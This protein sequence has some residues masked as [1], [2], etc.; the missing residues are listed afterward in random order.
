[1]LLPQI[2]E[3]KNESDDALDELNN[4]AID[5][6]IC[7]MT[8]NTQV[9]GLFAKAGADKIFLQKLKTYVVEWELGF[10]SSSLVK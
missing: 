2:L 6:M 8:K 3:Q 1:M 10:D 7:L 5:L 4:E 9:A